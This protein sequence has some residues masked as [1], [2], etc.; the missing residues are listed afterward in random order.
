MATSELAEPAGRV[1]AGWVVRFVLAWI[2]LYAGLFGP[3]QVL[4]PQQVE[5]L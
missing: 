4:L 2:G 3:I 1:S 5:A